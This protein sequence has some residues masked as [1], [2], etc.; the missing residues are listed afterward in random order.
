MQ[1]IYNGKPFYKK[2]RREPDSFEGRMTTKELEQKLSEIDYDSVFEV[3]E[4]INGRADVGYFLEKICIYIKEP[5]EDEGKLLYNLIPPCDDFPF[6]W[7]T[8]NDAVV[9]AYDPD[10][11]EIYIRALELAKRFM[12]ERGDKIND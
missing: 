4:F 12:P 2:W 3:K 10:D 8:T 7:L 1:T 6:W 11:L 5:C 9:N